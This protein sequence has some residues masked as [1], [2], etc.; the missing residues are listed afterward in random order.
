M[1]RHLLKKYLFTI[2]KY[3]QI[4]FVWSF[5]KTETFYC[6]RKKPFIIQWENICNVDFFSVSLIL[7]ENNGKS[8]IKSKNSHH[9]ELVL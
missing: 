1:K 6:N 3:V 2:F 8:P 4:S 9:T 5:I 7:L